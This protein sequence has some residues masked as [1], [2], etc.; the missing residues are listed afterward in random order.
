M[1]AEVLAG[2][3]EARAAREAADIALAKDRGDAHALY[4]KAL[5]ALH[6]ADTTL[7]RSLLEQAIAAG[8]GGRARV[9]LGALLLRA[10]DR[11]AAR[12]L[13]IAALHD[14]PNDVPALYDLALIEQQ[15]N[16]YHAAREGYLKVLR[17]DPHHLDA[18]YNLAVLT[19]GVGAHSEA[20][21]HVKEFQ[22]LA[23]AGDT[24]LT[25]LKELVQ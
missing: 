3:G 23:P 1:L 14:N 6:D 20:E 10:G 18:R 4:A 22:K 12:A 5:L 24:R 7:A 21:H 11:V 16:H 13:F 25:A 17:L 15:E 2:S 9:D 19:S 8:R